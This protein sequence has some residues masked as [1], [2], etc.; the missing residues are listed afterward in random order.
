VTNQFIL[1][2]QQINQAEKYML[3]EIESF[4]GNRLLHGKKL[5]VSEVKAFIRNIEGM[6]DPVALL[7]ARFAYEELPY[8]EDVRVDLTID[9]DTYRVIVWEY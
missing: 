8:R 2:P 4:Y 1:S 7:C 5:K 6:G 3:I 9:L